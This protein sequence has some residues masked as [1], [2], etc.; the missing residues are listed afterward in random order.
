MCDLLSLFVDGIAHG[1]AIDSEVKVFLA[2]GRIPVLERT[3]EQ[4]WIDTDQYITNDVLAE[5]EVTALFEKTAKAFTGLGDK[6]D[7]SY[8]DGFVDEHLAQDSYRGDYK[9]HRE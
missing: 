8:R 2:E 9:Q 7:S 6:V 4:G 1:L 5:N 3:V